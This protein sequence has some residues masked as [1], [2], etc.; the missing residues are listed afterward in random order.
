MKFLLI[1]NGTS[2]LS[3]LKNLLSGYSFQVIKY[4]ELSSINIDDFDVII[5]SGGHRLPIEGNEGLFCEEITLVKNSKQPIFGI[6]FG[7]EII[8]HAFGAKLERMQNKEHNI[9][10]I[11]INEPDSI[12]LDILNFQVFENHRWVVREVPENLMVLAVSKDGIEAIK[13][14]TKPIYAVQFHPEMFV[15]KTCGDEIFCN[16]LRTIKKI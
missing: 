8:A 7:F 1:D 2:Y 16:F 3:Q 10:D 5:L 4:F 11:K 6:C 13:H 9:I 12:F 14:K 15:E